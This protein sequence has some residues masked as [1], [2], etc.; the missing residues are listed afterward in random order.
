MSL[1]RPDRQEGDN[2]ESGNAVKERLHKHQRAV[3]ALVGAQGLEG[4]VDAG[5]DRSGGR[6]GGTDIHTGSGAGLP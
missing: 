5:A 3:L 6:V 1:D 4:S 2:D